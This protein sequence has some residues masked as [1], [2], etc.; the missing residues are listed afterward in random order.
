LT[1]WEDGGPRKPGTVLLFA[2]EG[3]WKCCLLDKDAGTIAFLTAG[4]HAELLKTVE[5][6][7]EAGTVEWRKQKPW[8]G[9]KG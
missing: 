9:R 2:E 7:L 5:K 3:R 4:T 1:A 6:Q 8:A